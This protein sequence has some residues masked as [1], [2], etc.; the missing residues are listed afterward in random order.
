MSKG[1]DARGP[2]NEGKSS[3]LDEE[4][5]Y[6]DNVQECVSTSNGLTELKPTGTDRT[7]KTVRDIDKKMSKQKSQE[8]KDSTPNKDIQWSEYNNSN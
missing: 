5:Q 3:R 7:E 2:W 8:I 6:I 1:D 4:W